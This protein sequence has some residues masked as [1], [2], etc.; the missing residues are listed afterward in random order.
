MKKIK[1]IL[2]AVLVIFWLIFPANV[3]AEDKPVEVQNSSASQIFPKLPQTAEDPHLSNGRVYPMWGPICQRYTYSVV[4][5]DDKNR[6]PEYVKMYFNGSWI[7]L[8]KED[9]NNSEYQQGVK[10]I[11]KFVPQKYGSNF[12]FF[13]A[14]N[15]QGKTRDSIIDSPDNGPVLFESDFTNNEITLIDPSS[16]QKLWTYPAGKEWVGGVALSD[17]GKYLAAKTSSHTLLFETSSSKPVRQWGKDNTT[18][19][20]GD[21]KGGVAISADG[22]TIFAAIGGQA[23]LF[24][25]DSQQPI[26]EYDL[27]NDAYNV[28]ISK[29]GKYLAAATAGEESNP[30]GNLLILWS[31]D[32]HQPLWQYHASGN[33]HDVSLTPDGSYI[34]GATGCPDRRAYIFSK[35]SNEPV[36]RSEMLTED[37][38]LNQA[39]I[40]SDGT[41]VAYSAEYNKG[42]VYLFKN[43]KL[44]GSN[45]P[46]WSF[47]ATKNARSG[48][49]LAFTPDGKTILETTFAGEIILFN[50]ANNTPIFSLKT[51]KPLGAAGISDDGQV[52]AA[53]GTEKKVFLIDQTT[54]SIKSE[55]TLSEYI[56]EISVSANGKYVAAGTGGSKYFFEKFIDD[57]TTVHQC[58]KISEP[59]AEASQGNQ[60]DSAKPKQNTPF[61]PI[62]LTIAGLIGIG[63]FVKFR[64]KW[65]LVIVAVAFLLAGYCALG[66]GFNF[67]KSNSANSSQ[68]KTP[69]NNTSTTN[70]TA[71]STNPSNSEEKSNTNNIQSSSPGQTGV[72]GNSLCEPDLGENKTS[73]PKDCSGGD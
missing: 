68:T 26:W 58:A 48:R 25:K 42:L 7:D 29:D 56:N 54:N 16:G 69:A 18:T 11:Y 55:I 71:S 43:P 67:N 66:Q 30:K 70:T 15:G 46:L 52:I 47:P 36:M 13:E 28:A 72:C 1:V 23:I 51:A 49:A 39:K 34:V 73:C 31:K 32:N 60:G 63:L 19:Q 38:P 24:S 5:Q 62:V 8:E 21:V 10:Y 27:G 12:Y 65:I 33:F 2:F 4:Y 17:D 9:K 57:E 6:P 20:V 14:S 40:S 45:Q 3:L 61:L 35:D 53:G 50:S 44:G 59:E 37:S 41:L 22:S 64:K